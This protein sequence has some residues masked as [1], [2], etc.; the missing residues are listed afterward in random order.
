[1]CYT[2][3]VKKTDLTKF[4]LPDTPGVYIFEDAQG[5]KIYIGK[6]TSLKQRVRSYFDPDLIN[7]RG[8]KI[9]T[10]VNSASSLSFIETNS[11]LEALILESKL[12]KQHNPYFNTKEKD[13]KSFYGVVITQEKFPRVLLMRLRDIEKKI[14]TGKQ[15]ALFG[16]F[17]SGSSL[18]EALKIVRT[19]FPFRDTCEEGSKKPC[20]NY[21][22]GLCPGVC[23]GLVSKEEYQKNINMIILF[24]EG[25]TKEVE[26]RLHEKMMTLASLEK[27]EEA[28]EVKRTLFSLKHIKD[29][30]LIK[31]DIPKDGSLRIESYDIAHISGSS[32]VGVMV[33]VE[34]GEPLKS[35]YKKFKLEESLVDDIAGYREML[36]RRLNHTEWPL[37]DLFVID[38]GI[39]QKNIAEAILKQRGIATPVITVVKDEAH[40]PK[41][42]LGSSIL[43]KKYKKDIVLS[44][45]EAH[46][47]AISYHKNIRSKKMFL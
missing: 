15:Q 7:T 44:N 27:F 23:A 5:Q 24:F 19:F 22:L 33:V 16:P 18:K 13:D 3:K 9:V 41:D 12:I 36:T 39:A 28:A 10:M 40:K 20:F 30:S 46:R 31:D 6:A 43:A 14:P 26:K 32:R 37:P 25:K 38:G 4:K 21:Q 47:F 42:L 17:T 29:V 34:N 2:T 8:V 35:D 45:A 1:M 11:S